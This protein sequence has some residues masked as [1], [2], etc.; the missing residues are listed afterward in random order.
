MLHNTHR[1]VYCTNCYDWE[2]D[3]I[4]IKVDKDYPPE[5]T[6]DPEGF[7]N[8]HE[9][10]FKRAL[11]AC[12][13]TAKKL[14]DKVWTM[15]NAKSYL[16][17]RGLNTKVADKVIANA[18]DEMPRQLLDVCPALCKPKY[19]MEVESF[20]P[21]VM[22]LCF[23]SVTKTTRFLIKE[24][25]NNFKKYSKFC[26]EDML[27]HMR[28]LVLHGAIRGLTVP[29]LRRMVRGPRKIISITHEFSNPFI[30]FVILYL[31]IGELSLMRRRTSLT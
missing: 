21:V 22:H 20:V 5:M 13:L 4:Q 15:K 24:T 3:R 10:T 17:V 16:K 23:L 31:Q 18:L 25:L 14:S 11:A 7:V 6:D 19:D 9:F 29:N 26:E 12:D 8:S 28:Y 30:Q 27:K 2:M 1:G